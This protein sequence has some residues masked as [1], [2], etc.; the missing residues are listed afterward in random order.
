MTAAVLTWQ[1]AARAALERS[2]DKQRL[3]GALAV[4]WH[5]GR[6]VL[7]EAAGY[8]DIGRGLAMGP[9][10]IFQIASMTKPIVT[11]AALQLVEEGKLALD[12]PITRWLPEFAGMRVLDDPAGPLDRTLP[13]ARPITV[14][15]LLTHRA[16]LGYAFTESGPVAAAY[17]QAL[18]YVLKSLRSPDEWIAA[19]AGLPLLYEPGERF[20]Y[21]H[22]TEVLGCLVARIDGTTLGQSLARRVLGPLGMRDTAFYVPSDKLPRL[23]H[24]YRREPIGFTDV[25]DAPTAPPL[26]EAG[27]GGLYS[28]AANYLT[29]ARLLVGGGMVDGVRLLSAESC[30][31]MLRNHLTDRQRSLGGLGQPDFFKNTGFGYGVAVE[32][33]PAPPLFLTPGSVSWGGVFGTG[34]RADP[35]NRIV[36]LFFA[37]DFADTSSGPERRTP[38]EVTPAAVLQ[39]EVEKLAFDALL[40]RA[41][42]A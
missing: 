6:I 2:I 4:A 24:I 40:S 21:S 10:A 42:V 20:N 15:D 19:L 34:W 23:A 8:R 41:G 16:G 29:F 38:G 25:T 18:G 1:Q 33:A 3:A 11:I 22:A 39:T 27:G 28:T 13:A 17:E 26:F 14:D 30:A 7:N 12:A 36:T 37:Q 35:A 31:L 9:D 32:L 5:D